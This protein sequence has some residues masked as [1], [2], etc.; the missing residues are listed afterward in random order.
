MVQ[1]FPALEELEPYLQSLR[2]LIRIA[3]Q[4]EGLADILV[5]PEHWIGSVAHH[6]ADL[7]RQELERVVQNFG[8]DYLRSSARHVTEGQSVDTMRVNFAIYHGYQGPAWYSHETAAAEFREMF[9][10]DQVREQSE[11]QERQRRRLEG[12]QL[13]N[14]V[15]E[16]CTVPPEENCPLCYE[17]YDVDHIAVKTKV[18]R[19][20]FGKICLGNWLNTLGAQTSCPMCRQIL[21]N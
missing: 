5:P 10:F 15:T 20:V 8:F 19:H 1:Y 13:M 11:E 18:C 21:A 3:R 7:Y 16:D 6:T 17:S 4:N 9:R 12:E 2:E 14:T